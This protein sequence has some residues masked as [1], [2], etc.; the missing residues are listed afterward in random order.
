MTRQVQIA[1]ELGEKLRR[2]RLA[3]SLTLTQ[4]AER[5]GLSEAFLSRLER[6]QAAASV[7]NLIQI[8]DAL[9]IGMHDLF[10]QDTRVQK[11]TVA[12]HRAK[13]D[14]PAPI[15]E[16][17]GYRWRRLGGGAPRDHLG[18]FLLIFAKGGK[19]PVMVSHAGQEHCAVL[20]GEIDFYVGDAVHRLRAG[21]GIFITSDL[22]HRVAN[23]GKSE[24]RLLMTAAHA[25]QDASGE[26]W[27]P[28]IAG[29]K[30]QPVKKKQSVMEKAS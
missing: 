29:R 3:N 16:A 12:V 28:G 24:A 8:T 13:G 18:A 20:A 19:M 7:A 6:A 23:V 27:E 5:A 17:Q 11:T 21:D 14:K 30:A 9:G 15:V 26:W 4:L 25:P 1:R 10:A 22:P 2:A